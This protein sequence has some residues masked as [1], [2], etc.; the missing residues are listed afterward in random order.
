MVKLQWSLDH[1]KAGKEAGAL[2]EEYKGAL[3]EAKAGA[4]QTK[5]DRPDQDP[6]VRRLAGV[7]VNSSDC[8]FCSWWC[9]CTR[10][11]KKIHLLMTCNARH[12]LLDGCSGLLVFCVM[13]CRCLQHDGM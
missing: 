1:L 9:A 8:L 5:G 4:V 7:P 12:A 11:A 3:E 6:Q 10:N 2:G 13:E